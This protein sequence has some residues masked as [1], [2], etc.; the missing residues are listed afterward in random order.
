MEMKKRLFPYHR[1][2]ESPSL[3][4]LLGNLASIFRFRAFRPGGVQR[5]NPRGGAGRGV[6]LR[7]RYIGLGMCC[8]MPQ[9]VW[10]FSLFGKIV[11][12]FPFQ[13]FFSSP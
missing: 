9:G 12:L 6:F 13:T 3:M 7:E 1:L 5:S 8:P 2:D 4:K 11:T 10:F